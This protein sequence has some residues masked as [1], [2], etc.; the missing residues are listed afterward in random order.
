MA[1]KKKQT[2]KS[3]ILLKDDQQDFQSVDSFFSK[4]RKTESP[5]LNIPNY[6][7]EW[8]SLPELKKLKITEKEAVLNYAN[9]KQFF[10]QHTNKCSLDQE[11]LFGGYH[12][13][14]NRDNQKILRAYSY[15]CPYKKEYQMLH[16]FEDNFIYRS[17]VAKNNL[18]SINEV[19]NDTENISKLNP[20]TRDIIES[21]YKLF[22][23]VKKKHELRTGF[24]YS[25]GNIGKTYN[26]ISLCN[27]L[28]QIGYKVI[29]IDN[30]ELSTKFLNFSSNNDYEKWIEIFK[31]V[32]IL[33]IDNFGMESSKSSW[34]YGNVL[35][36][37]LESRNT[38]T[39]MTG[40]ISGYSRDELKKNL[41]NKSKLDEVIVNWLF[42]KINN[43]VQTRAKEIKDTTK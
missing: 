2:Q 8:I 25:G 12:I 6:I 10:E 42:G 13:G 33:V 23:W 11:C 36:G 27:S 26:V 15:E 39:K 7:K 32:D 35:P 3:D 41:I 24:W 29:Y 38:K 22:N 4:K 31:D 37:I 17:S 16:N 1:T 30:F 40:F 20:K 21:F 18:L 5:I 43:L 19:A 34:F 28:A 14:F 9:L